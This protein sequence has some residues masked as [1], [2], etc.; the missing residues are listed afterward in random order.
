MT[1]DLDNIEIFPWNDNLETGI[2]IIDEQHKNLVDLLNKLIKTL[3]KQDTVELNSIFDELIAYTEYHF[4]TEEKIWN[5]YL[6]DDPWLTSHHEAH[7][8]FLPT[9]LRIKNEQENKPLKEV[10]EEIIKHLIRWLALHI[11]N[12]DKRMAIVVQNI[13][14]GC[15]LDEAKTISDEE[16]NGASNV[17]I[18][19]VLHI[20]NQV[21]TRTLE[22]MYERIDKKKAEEKLKKLN[23]ELEKFATTDKL[24]GLF[25][26]RHYD[27]IFTREMG[28]AR[29]EKRELSLILFDI[30]YFKKLNDLY[31]HAQGDAALKNIAKKL[32][33]ICRRP[34]DFVFRLGGEEFGVLI[35]EQDLSGVSKLAEIIRSEIEALAI[36]NINSDIADHVTISAGVM[37][38]VPNAEDTIDS[39][40]HEADLLLYKAKES[41]RNQII[42]K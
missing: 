3:V 28:R 39:F 38:K 34:G 1:S 9:V 18:N 15:S 17:L 2:P 36:P 24:T 27:D 32:K 5:E 26:R 12:S 40:F 20:Y 10:A 25:N 6:S 42:F 29:R 22:L 37:C 30:D 13:E 35:T 11:I 33:H 16:M 31:G 4:D 19:V 23:R 21:S 41:G 7:V 8:S 14:N